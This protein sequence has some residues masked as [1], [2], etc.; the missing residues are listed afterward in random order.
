[1]S[2]KKQSS[3]SRK[4]HWVQNVGLSIVLFLIFLVSMIGQARAGFHAYNQEQVEKHLPMLHSIWEYLG[5]GHFLSSVF[6]N[7]ESEFLQMALFVFL[8]ACLY[9]KG[10]A[11][12]KPPP[13]DR[14]KEEIEED[15]A[16]ERYCKDHAKRKPIF[17][18]IYENSLTLAL[19]GLF[20]VFFLLHAYGSF[21]T[22]REEKLLEHEAP[23]KFFEIFGTSEFWF[24]SFQ[25]WQSEFFSIMVLGF[26]TIFLRQRGSPQS[27]KM[28]DPHSKTGP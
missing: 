4:S 22:K 17:W 8:T 13:A 12:S 19:L 5:Q 3:S 18:R 28:Y 27:K 7:M 9:Q 21:L 10:S 16:E 20:A 2:S 23:P 14:T 24:E 6:E 26:L 11:E 15:A 1:M 25:N